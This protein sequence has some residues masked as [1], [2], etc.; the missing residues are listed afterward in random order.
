MQEKKDIFAHADVHQSSVRSWR[1]LLEQRWVWNRLEGRGRQS[2]FIWREL[3]SVSIHY[4]LSL[5]TGR[6]AAGG[7]AVE[8][9]VFQ[10]V[11]M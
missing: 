3:L 8:N 4:Y 10:K 9:W 2:L 6:G 1:I 5:L 11:S 7:H